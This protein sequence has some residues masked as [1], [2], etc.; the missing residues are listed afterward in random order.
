MKLEYKVEELET[1]NVVG[2]F[3]VIRK[4]AD[5]NTN[6]FKVVLL[7]ENKDSAIQQLFKTVSSLLS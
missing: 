3:L 5:L 1:L 4:H 6:S 7:L 2:Y